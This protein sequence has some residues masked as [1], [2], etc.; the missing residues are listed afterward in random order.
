MYIIILEKHDD[1]VTTEERVYEEYIDEYFIKNKARAR[2][3][4]NKFK[5]IKIINKFTLDELEEIESE[6]YQE[7]FKL[8][9]SRTT[10]RLNETIK[11]KYIVTEFEKYDYHSVSCR[12]IGIRYFNNI[13]SAFYSQFKIASKKIGAGEIRRIV[14]NENNPVNWNGKFFCWYHSGELIIDTNAQ[15]GILNGSYIEYFS[16][17]YS[18]L[19][20]H[21]YY[22]TKDLKNNYIHGHIRLKCHYANGLEEGQLIE[23]FPNGNVKEIHMCTRGFP[24]K[25]TISFTYDG[26]IQSVGKHD[27]DG[28]QG[29]YI[30]FDETNKICRLLFFDKELLK[31]KETLYETKEINYTLIESDKVGKNLLQNFL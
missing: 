23:W 24:D 21:E 17:T 31:H 11:F 20:Y 29:D 8:E 18:Y 9:K 14:D 28:R 1:T 5:V 13:A 26:N 10:W 2:F 3:R 6:M 7:D 30:E 4:G 19:L 25:Y 16:V 12:E 27:V 15:N 22:E